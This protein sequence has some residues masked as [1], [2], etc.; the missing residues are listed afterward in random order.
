MTTETPA[1][2]N[3][4]HLVIEAGTADKHYWRDLW[5]YR[6]LFLILAWRDV[7]VRYKQTFI[8]VAWAF[9]Q[10]ALTIIIFSFIFG[11]LAGMESGGTP[12]LIL[13]SA[14]QL[15]WQFFSMS[16]SQASNSLVSAQN[17]LSKV[18]FPRLVV[19]TGAIMVSF[20]DFLISAGI[21]AA[22]MVW[23]QFVPTWRVVFIP[24]L[25]LLVFCT[26]LGIGLWLATLNVYYRDFRIIVPFIVQFGL[27]IS[28][29]GYR[30]EI[31]LEKYG[32]LVYFL[33]CLNPMVGVIDGFRWAVL[34]NSEIYMPGFLLSIGLAVALL[35]SGLWFFR[36]MEKTF[37][38]YI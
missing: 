17:M 12:Y 2:K 6:D 24:L 29:V 18:Y 10:P 37:A 20:V 3:P 28:P 30:S 15:P 19:P 9:L 11:G 4:H 36:R 27:F 22:L 32:E 26:A 21:L 8:G 23:F 5:H 31:I 7:A 25:L 13:V 16:L 38:D 34:G 33:Y 14:A 1:D 35:A